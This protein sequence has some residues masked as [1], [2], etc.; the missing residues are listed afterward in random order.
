[1]VDAPGGL[2]GG[3]GYYTSRG[4]NPAAP[5]EVCDG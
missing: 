5:V 2:P 4:S 3:V 1:M